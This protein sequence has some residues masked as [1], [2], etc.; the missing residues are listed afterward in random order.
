MATKCEVK[1][2]LQ[3]ILGI[4]L[5]KYLA[6]FQF[7]RRKSSLIYRRNSGDVIQEITLQLNYKPK[8]QPGVDAHIYPMIKIMIPK[9]SGRID[10]Y[11]EQLLPIWGKILQH[12]LIGDCHKMI[13]IVRRY[14]VS[15][16]MLMQ[17]EC[18]KQANN[19]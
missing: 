17:T 11:P 15:M 8:Y 14:L 12:L 5:D 2:L 9:V 1:S 19:H 10:I 16:N 18:L 6:E 13:N 3:N 4:Y 7:S